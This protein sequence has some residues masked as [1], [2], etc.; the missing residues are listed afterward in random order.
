MQAVIL[1]G[2]QATRL[3]P[4]TTNTPKATVPV[5]NRPFLEY[6]IRNLSRHGVNDI[7]LAQHHLAGP[8]EENL[9]DGTRFGVSI[10]YVVEDSPRGTAGAFKN[11]EKH[12]KGTFLG[13][14][15]D[16]FND[17]DITSMVAFHKD[18]NAA[19]TI[20]LTPVEDPTAYGLIETDTTGRVKRFLEKPTLSEITTNM[21]N[22]GTYVLEPE[23]LE[24]IPPEVQ[25][26]IERETF[27]PLVS[28]GYPVFAFPSSG[29]WMDMGTPE[30]YLQLHRD[31]LAGRSTWYVPEIE[32]GVLI[33]EGCTVD[34]SAEI[35]GPVIVGNNCSIGPY[36][37][38]TGPAVIG[39]GCAIGEGSDIEDSVLWH[40]VRL[41]SRVK[42]KSSAVADN[43]TLNDESIIQGGVFGDHVTVSAG[44]ILE[45]GSMIEPGE[46]VG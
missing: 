45:S 44:A 42:L 26:S 19:A 13:M 24:Q 40:N 43:C 46:T 11:V 17:L 7:V 30:K 29:Y 3:R 34:P 18:N 9:G 31:L 16:I 15:G 1:V 14:N 22:A 25:V 8:I 6:V 21:I 10:T 33:G 28:G 39:D 37:Q 36:V 27:P 41:G 20:A 35:V 5:L 23:V 2:G 4:L 12:I 32:A 38:I